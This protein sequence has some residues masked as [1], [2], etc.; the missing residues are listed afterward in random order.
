[1]STKRICGVEL[2]GSEA[3]VAIVELLPK[4]FSYLDLET[5]KIVLNPDDS[6]ESARAFHQAFA[7]FVKENN[8]DE[9]VI[10][11]RQKKGRMGGG[12]D[13]F[14]MEALIQLCPDLTTHL[15]APQTIAA[16]EKKQGIELPADIK[17][18]Q[19]VAFKTVYCHIRKL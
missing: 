8:I 10:K 6:S 7:N 4:G 14:K 16:V 3:I 12:G 19:E 17:K 15:I 11:K 9:V 2:K 1:M 13:S 5:R 18:Y